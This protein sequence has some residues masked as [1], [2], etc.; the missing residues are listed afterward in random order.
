MCSFNLK[1]KKNWSICGS[2]TSMTRKLSFHSFQAHHTD[3]F[4]RYK[5]LMRNFNFEQYNRTQSNKLAEKQIKPHNNS[6]FRT[7]TQRLMFTKYF[8]VISKVDDKVSASC[9]HCKCK[10]VV[11]SRLKY[12]ATFSRHIKVLYENFSFSG[13]FFHITTSKD[14]LFEY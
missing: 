2:P 6:E 9:K 5:S 3:E 1:K 4:R 7:H 8:D 13:V 12:L 14:V 11:T 10:R